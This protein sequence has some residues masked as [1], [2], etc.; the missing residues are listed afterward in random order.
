M[1]TCP[2]GDRQ[3]QDSFLYISQMA[4]DLEHFFHELTSHLCVLFSELFSSLFQSS[5]GFFTGLWFWGS[6]YIMYVGLLSDE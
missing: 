1:V 4:K 3:S 2:A 5:V 6:L